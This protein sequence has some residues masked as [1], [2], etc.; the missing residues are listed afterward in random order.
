MQINKINSLIANHKIKNIGDNS[1]IVN[2]DKSL[3]TPSEESKLE[4]I[5]ANA[6]AI[7]PAAILQITNPM[8]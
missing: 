5:G 6:L 2:P 4:R 1:D 7:G 3:V 8:M